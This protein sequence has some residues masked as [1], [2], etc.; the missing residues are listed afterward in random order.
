MKYL[1]GAGAGAIFGYLVL[2]K[3]IGCAGGSCPITS[4]PFISMAYGV[5]MGGLLLSS[6]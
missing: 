3:L 4:S 5:V 1:V 2:Y 6:F